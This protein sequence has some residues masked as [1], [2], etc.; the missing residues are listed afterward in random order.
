MVGLLIASPLNG[1][2]VRAE[3]P[4]RWE[5]LFVSAPNDSWIEAGDARLD[6]DD[7]RN[8]IGTN[9]EGVLISTKTGARADR[10]LVSEHL[11]DDVELRLEFLLAKG[12]NAGVKLQGL[13]EVQL[14]DSHGFSEPDATHAGGIYPRAVREPHYYHIDAG[15]RPLANAARP[16]GEWQ[17]LEIRFRAPRFDDTGKKTSPAVFEEVRLNGEVVQ[18]MTS[19]DA[20]T[21]AYWRRAERP[22]GPIYLQGD[23]GPV[24]Y[25]NVRVRPLAPN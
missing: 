11:F 8:L 3:E 22:T 6:A 13:Y 18:R 17:S 14:F 4:E 12:S 19:V 15:T 7:P 16:A 9:G 20:P 23:H 21:G 2:V 5:R 25:R 24:A 1:L 10:N